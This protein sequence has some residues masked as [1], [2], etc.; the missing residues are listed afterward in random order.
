MIVGIDP[1]LTG[2]IAVLHGTRLEHIADMPTCSSGIASRP[3]SRQVDAYALAAILRIHAMDADIVAVERVHALPKQGVSGVF[4]FGHSAG[5]VAGV[6]G[7]LGLSVVYVAPQQWK[8]GFGLIG[9]DKG[10]SVAKAVDLF[11]FPEL[12]SR[13]KDH[14]RADAMLI[15]AWASVERK[16][17]V[18]PACRT[19][20]AGVA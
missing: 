19:T 17:A 15:A 2:A 9:Q 14:G 7:A 20:V 4:S 18:S 3:K 8:R 10:A 13:K 16:T 1:G 6:C 12:L 5:V 11:R